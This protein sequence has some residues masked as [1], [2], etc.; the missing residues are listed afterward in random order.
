MVAISSMVYKASAIENFATEEVRSVVLKAHRRI[1]EA[2][3]GKD[4][5]AARR[6]MARHLAALTAAVKAFPSAPLVLE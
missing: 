6:R 2:I 1:F 3:A 4:T 5:E